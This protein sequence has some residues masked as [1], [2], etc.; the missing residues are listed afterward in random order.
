MRRTNRVEPVTTG[1]DNNDVTR[2]TVTTTTR[3]ELVRRVQVV[4]MVSICQY[5][6]RNIGFNCCMSMRI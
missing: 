5:S 3:M 1:G 2:A 4:P 6:M